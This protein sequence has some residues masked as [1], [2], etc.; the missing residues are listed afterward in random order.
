MDDTDDIVKAFLGESRESLDQLDGELLALEQDPSNREKLASVFRTI[1]S[2]KGSG[3]FLGF[4]KLQALAHAG[5]SL[6]AVLRDG[7]VE[8]TPES[9]SALLALV[10]G[11]RVMLGHIET[12][13]QDGDDT[14]AGLIEQLGA[15]RQVKREALPATPTTLGGATN[16]A[17]SLTIPD[18]TSPAVGSAIKETP[19][20]SSD[21]MVAPTTSKPPYAPMGELLVKAGRVTPEHVVEALREQDDGDPRH[22]G[23]ILAEKGHVTAPDIAHAL[24]EQKGSTTDTTLRVDVGLLDKLMNLVGELVLARNQIL[25][26]V[27]ALDDSTY[28][29]ASQRL[30]LITSELQEGIM[31]TRMQTIGNVWRKLPRQVRDLAHGCGKN[32]RIEMEGEETELDKTLVETIRDPI[33]HIVRNCIDHGIED[34][35]SRRASG[36]P[37]QGCLSLR[38]YHEGGLVNVEIKDDGAGINLEAVK[39]KALSKGLI[40][41][42]QAYRMS[43]REA[44]NLI[45]LPG[46]ST[47]PAVTN[48]SGRGVGMDVVKTNIH[49]I[50]GTVDISSQCGVGTTLRMKIPLT[51]AIIP[52]LLILSG[53]D[54]YAIP[55]VNLVELLR[56]E[57]ERARQGIETLFDI[58]VYRLRGHLLPLV[59]LN[60]VLGRAPA[61][62]KAGAEP[63]HNIV[64]LQAGDRQFGLVVDEINDTE[65]IVV[66]PLGKQLKGVSV[67]AGA[68]V[69][70]DGRVALILDVPGLAKAANVVSEETDRILSESHR[71]AH[72]D[73][74]G[75]AKQTLL[76]LRGPDDARLAIPLS[77]VSRLEEF[78]R[79]IVEHMGTQDV[80]QYRGQIL[81]L[82]YLADM[83]PERR[84]APRHTTESHDPSK[85]QVVVY[86]NRGRGIG[87]VVDRILDIIEDPLNV[88]RPAKR[89]GVLFS[90]VIQDRITELLDIDSIVRNADPAFFDQP[91][92]SEG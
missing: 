34:P 49:K 62:H 44:T 45:F 6:L 30:N 87:L 59:Y 69:M 18:K 9:M 20:P 24:Q 73:P 51:L 17:R 32:V 70:G 91:L 21:S 92:T 11:V 68:T 67:F 85:L 89:D 58:P 50:G 1:H 81:P 86:S 28:A 74:H 13:G 64:V 55:Q 37:E 75:N 35:R 65:E 47:A 39:K 40:T 25:Q 66:K 84:T 48:I 14:Y 15:L 26:L 56:L 82:I 90:A 46:F 12:T 42:D 63:T 76:L 83:L 41:P 80:V 5:E 61:A 52:A 33:V 8:P 23:E 43:D 16:A 77:R 60:R 3:G 4:Q 19:A 54:R 79:T 27:T 2:V 78:P 10:D 31:K 29:A 22:V 72:S 71:G 88:Q 38:A 57:D 7:G 53:E 36:K